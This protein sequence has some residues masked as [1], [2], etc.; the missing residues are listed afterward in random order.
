M[1][2]LTEM[3]C[4]NAKPREKAYKLFDGGGLYAEVK[5]NGSILWYL[6]F[7]YQGTERRLAI[8][9]YPLNSLK[10]AREKRDD[11]KR[12]LAEGKDPVQEKRKRKDQAMADM[13][14]TFEKIAREWHGL[15]TPD[16]TPEHAQTILNRLEKDVFPIIGK[17]PI[18]NLKHKDLLDMAKSI[19]ERGANELAKR[20]IQ[21]SRHIFQYAII[22]GR[23]DRNLA[24]DLRGLI[25]A[26][27]K[28]HFA[29]LDIKDLPE[30]LGALYTNEARLMPLTHLAVQFMMLTFVRTG[31]MIAAEWSE[32]DF[33]EKMWLVP[34]KRM[35]MNK[36]HLVPLSDQALDVLQKIRDQHTNQT[37]VFPSRGNPRNHMSNNTILMALRRMGYQGQMTGHGFRSLAMSTIMEKLGYRHEVP[38]RQLAHSKRGDVNKAYD[39][40]MFLDERKVMMQD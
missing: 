25:K 3:Q 37:Y 33:E 26:K 13:A 29:S 15:H 20:V 28:K 34:A 14:N 5:P 9:P 7:Y 10:E 19:Q 24:E 2:K 31:E 16:W 11:A 36:D 38:D 35:K 22:T 4:R 18:K 21:M 23:A 17:V 8:G 40:A 1:G 32:F 27:P 30:F 39:R 6:K 12:L